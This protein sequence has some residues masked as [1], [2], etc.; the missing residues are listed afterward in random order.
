MANIA[1][2]N[3]TLCTVEDIRGRLNSP[4][5]VLQWDK[6]AAD[7]DSVIL[8]KINLS[9]DWI[10]QDLTL[11]LK[12]RIPELVNSWLSYKR[13]QINQSMQNIRRDLGQISDAAGLPNVGI[14]GFDG[15]IFDLFF[16]LTQF[17]QIHP[18]TFSNYGAPTN[19]LLNGSAFTGDILVDT[20]GWRLY[21]NKGTLNATIWKAEFTAVDA[22]DNI[23]NIGQNAIA[24]SLPNELIHVQVNAALWAMAQDGMFRNQINYD[25]SVHSGFVLDT[26][27]MWMK[28]Y[29]SSVKD[30]A[31]L[32]DVD[33][34]GDGI[35]SDYERGIMTNEL[36]VF[37]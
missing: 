34:D 23:L 14:I 24:N 31:P 5:I 1:W 6:D 25:D 10:R 16:F 8:Q 29:K 27:A 17:P 7:L 22:L 36:A 26:E 11:D 4:E 35:I 19:G 33:I 12:K 37:G 32:L 9:K 28:R 18:R 3:L 13:F 2:K 20:Y 30:V 21:I 15:T